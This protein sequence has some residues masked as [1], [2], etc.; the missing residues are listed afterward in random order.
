MIAAFGKFYLR[1]GEWWFNQ[2]KPNG[3]GNGFLPT[4]NF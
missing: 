4:S 3:A 1:N 2:Y